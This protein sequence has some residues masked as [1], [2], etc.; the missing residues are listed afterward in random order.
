MVTVVCGTVVNNWLDACMILAAVV[1]IILHRISYLLSWQ[2]SFHSNVD[3]VMHTG[4]QTSGH[5]T[6]SLIKL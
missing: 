1:V 2:G 6:T 3:S 4:R 5:F